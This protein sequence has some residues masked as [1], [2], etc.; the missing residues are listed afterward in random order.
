VVQALE[1]YDG[2]SWEQDGFVYM[3]G[4]IYILNNKKFMIYQ[5]WNIQDNKG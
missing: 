3:E 1:K 4:R 2:L 5:M